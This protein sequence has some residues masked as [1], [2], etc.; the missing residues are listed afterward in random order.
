MKIKDLFSLEGKTAIVTG[1]GRG[2]GEQ[3]AFG[4]A[5][6]RSNIVVCSRKLE[7][8]EEIAHRIKSL[9]VKTLALRC[10]LTREEEIDHV[11]R[12]T[13]KE[14]EKIDILVNNSGRTWGASVEEFNME[15][16]KKV[17]DLNITGTF[18]ITQ[19]VGREM[20]KQKSGKI[21]NMV[22]IAGLK[23]TDPDYLNSIAYNTSKGALITFT[24]DLAVKWA[25]YRIYVNAIAPGWFVTEMTKWSR[26]H[27]EKK[28]LDRIL[29][30]KFGGEDD[31]KGAVVFLASKASDYVTGQILCV[32]GGLTAW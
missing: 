21:I 23:G 18:Q 29:I 4:L 16:W 8:C 30:K 11:I 2:L 25:K 1:G 14:F 15:G 27:Y 24:K 7:R 9:G 26:E 3:I 6:A 5:E 17:I 12:E 31:L 10:D 28:M 19:K 13:I 22:S 32:D 20:I